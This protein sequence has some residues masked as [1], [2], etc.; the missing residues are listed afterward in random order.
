MRANNR[1]YSVAVFGITVCSSAL[2]FGQG[3]LR[4]EFEPKEQTVL[5]R[6]PLVVTLA[7]RNVSDSTVKTIFSAR[8]PETLAERATLILTDENAHTDRIAYRGGPIT[9]SSEPIEINPLEPGEA[10]SVE[11]LFSLV[12]RN[13]SRGRKKTIDDRYDFLD[14]GTYRAYFEVYLLRGEK[15]HSEEFDLVIRQA[16]AEDALAK[17]RL[18]VRHAAFLEGRDRPPLV[19]SY[20]ER[21][22]SD[23]LYES[24][25]VEIQQILDDFPE[26]TYAAWIRFWKVYYHGPID[27]A[28]EYARAHPDF[29]LSDNIMLRMAQSLFQ[30]K[31]F[32][33]AREIVAEMSQRFPDGDTRAAVQDL[34]RML[35]NK[36]H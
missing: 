30:D 33:R 2:S 29:A 15:L 14:P 6:L 7:V 12:T 9:C 4:L 36:P 21:K 24:R 3:P 10:H 35:A 26:S 34:Q 32:G 1:Q 17:E 13:R 22:A 11:R 18:A 28:V 23:R 5:E 20:H 27:D 19:S 25:F 8:D 16:E 31:Q